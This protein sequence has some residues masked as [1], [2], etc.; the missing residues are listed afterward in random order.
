MS[1]PCRCW[2]ETWSPHDGHC[3]FHPDSPEDCHDAEAEVERLATERTDR[4]AWSGPVM[5]RRYWLTEKGWAA[6]GGRPA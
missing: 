2:T 1:A 5:D 4:R 6:T 3:C